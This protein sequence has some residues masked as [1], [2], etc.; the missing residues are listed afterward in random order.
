MFSIIS[1]QLVAGVVT[2]LYGSVTGCSNI[3]PPTGLTPEQLDSL[4]NIQSIALIT[5]HVQV[6]RQ[7]LTAGPGLYERVIPEWSE[8]AQSNITQAIAKEFGKLFAVTKLDSGQPVDAHLFVTASDEIKTSGR[9]GMDTLGLA[10]GAF[11]MPMIYVTVVPMVLVMNPKADIGEFNRGMLKAMW[12]AGLTTLKVEITNPQS[13]DILWS[14]TK[15]S[16]SGYDLRDPASVESLIAEAVQDLIKAI[17]QGERSGCTG[18]A[19]N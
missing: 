19:C 18:A 1:R 10:Y 17:S 4:S 11:L 6:L 8:T 16:R 15:E 13:G 2:V 9:R 7:G 5:P 3:S 14:F 12:P